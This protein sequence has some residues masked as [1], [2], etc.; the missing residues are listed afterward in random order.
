MNLRVPL[1]CDG[2]VVPSE[3]THERF[4]ALVHVWRSKDNCVEPT[5]FLAL[6]GFWDLSQVVGA[7]PPMP[8]SHPC[9]VWVSVCCVC[10]CIN[11]QRRRGRG[12]A[13]PFGLCLNLVSQSLAEWLVTSQA[14]ATLVPDPNH[15]IRSAGDHATLDILCVGAGE[16]NSG[17]CA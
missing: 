14:E 2:L 12:V 1:P 15:S 11:V 9:L 4:H 7:L 5:R 8:C 13:L 6:C 10:M 16:Q 3:G 17:F